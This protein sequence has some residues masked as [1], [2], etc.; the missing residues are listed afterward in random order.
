ML[1]SPGMVVL[2]MDW[3]VMVVMIEM[4]TSTRSEQ[5][6]MDWVNGSCSHD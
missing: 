2:L 4:K 6:D 3:F 1:R 5:P